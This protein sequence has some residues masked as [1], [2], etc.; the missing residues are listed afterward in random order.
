MAGDAPCDGGS[1]IVIQPATG[2]ETGAGCWTLPFVSFGLLQY[3]LKIGKFGRY[4]SLDLPEL[5]DAFAVEQIAQGTEPLV[6]TV[7]P[8]IQSVIMRYLRTL[9]EIVELPLSLSHKSFKSCDLPIGSKYEEIARWTLGHECPIYLSGGR[10]VLLYHFLNHIIKRE[11]SA[12]RAVM[13]RVRT[14]QPL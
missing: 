12:P 7:T 4:L 8:S 10:T 6:C 13:A 3:F 14:L 5:L 11:G 2:S 9:H 1:L